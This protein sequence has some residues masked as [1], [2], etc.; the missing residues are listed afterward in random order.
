MADIAG[1]DADF[2][3]ISPREARLMDPQQRLAL[4]VAWEAL[5]HAGIPPRDLTGSDTGV[6]V[7]VG[8]DDYGRRLLEDLPR[9]EAWTGIGASPCGVANR[10]SHSLDLRGPS[11]AVDTACSS[12]LVAVHQAAQSLRLGEIPLALAGG[13]MLMAGPGLSVVLDA[14]GAIS[15]D[16]RSK[17][18]DAAADG[19]GRGEGG[20]FVVLKRL[21]D[22]Q[23]DGDRVL[24][25]IKGGAVHQDGRTEGIMAPSR[26]AQ[27]RLLRLAHQAAGVDPA[28]IDYVEAHGT[29]TR[30]GDPIEAGALAAVLGAGRSVDRPCLIGSLKPNIGHLEAGA[31]VAGLI[32]ASLAIDRG[33]I[34]ATL[35]TAGP[36]PA[37]AWERSG[38]ALVTRLTPWPAAV[39]PRRAGV[40]SYGYGGTIAYVVLE[41]TPPPVE[42]AAAASRPGVPHL[43]PLSGATPSGAR[44]NAARLADWLAAHSDTADRHA[45]LADVGRTLACH[46]SHLPARAVV[47][48]VNRGELIDGLRRVRV[49][50]AAEPCDPVWVFSGH[51]AQWV[52]MGRG[53]L[54][55][56][57]L[58]AEV[59]DELEP[60]YQEEVGFSPRQVLERGDLSRVDRIQAVTFAMQVGLAAVWRAYG[61]RAAAVI[62]HS[63]GEIAAAVAAGVL[64]QPDG[65]RLACRRSQLLRRV[66]GQGA[67]TM[68]ALPSDEVTARLAGEPEVSVAVV[69]SPGATV[70]AGT[71]A[72]VARVT[73]RFQAEGLAVRP[74]D[75][76]V[77]F[78]SAQMDRL[79]ADLADAARDLKTNP[80]EVPLYTTALADPRDRAE[81]DA[82][83]WAANLR[84]PVRF[85]AA[86]AAAAADGHRVFLEISAHP[87]VAHSIIQTV[88]DA[89]VAHTL[90]RGRPERRT[91]LENLGALHCHGVPVDWSVLHPGGDLVDMPTTAWRHERHWV[92]HPPAAAGGRGHDPAS[93]TLLGERTTV[94]G[95]TPVQLWRTRLDHAC[96]PYPGDHPV[97]GIEVVPAAVLLHTFL[98]AAGT[99]ALRDVSLQVPLA[100]APDRE[101]QV[102]CQD[103]ALRLSSRVDGDWLTHATA[104]VDSG[105][106]APVSAARL[107]GA[108]RD[109]GFVVER[110]A[111]LGVAAMGFPWRVEE[112]WRGEGTLSARVA[113]DPDTS[114]SSLTWAAVLDAALSA[115]S[116]VFPGPAVLRMPAHVAD[117]ALAGDPPA[118]ALIRVQVTGDECVDVDIAAADGAPAGRLG[119][120]S[121]GRPEAG[122]AGPGA[123]VYEIAWRPLAGQGEDAPLRSVAL[124]G[125]DPGLRAA[126]SREGILR[127]GP[128]ADAV[129]VAPRPRPGED[130]GEAALRL[131]LLL[132]E[133]VQSARGGRLWCVTR[134]A[135][136]PRAASGLAQTALWGLGRIAAGERPDRWGG[137]VDLPATPQ[138]RDIAALVRLLRGRW[139]EDLIG[140]DHGVATTARLAPTVTARPDAGPACR[141]DGTYLITGGTGALGLRVAQWLASRGAR[142]LVL[143]G[144]RPDASTASRPESPAP[145][146][147]PDATAPAGGP[148]PSRGARDLRR[149]LESVGVTVRVLSADVCDRDRMAQL[150]DPDTLGLPRIRGVVHAAGVIDNRFIHALDE[151][152]LRDVMRPKVTG[153]LV[154]HELFPPGS[155]DFFVLFSSAGQ[156]LR[157]PGQAAYAAGNA[158]LDGLARH[159]RATG[160]HETLSLAWTSWR[161]LGMSTSSAAVDAELAAHGTADITATEALRAWGHADS[162][163]AGNLAVLRVL[164]GSGGPPLLRDLTGPATAATVEWAHLT[165]P[166]RL[167]L[168]LTEARRAAAT[169]L[170]VD[171]DAL[172]THRPLADLGVDSLLSV[173]LRCILTER[174]GVPVPATLLW[175]HPTVAAVATY[176]ASLDTR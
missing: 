60:I 143:L 86:V 71:P 4:E 33:V 118:E 13:V 73:A 22:A 97:L 24:A 130:P 142:R 49:S 26:Q 37:I 106:A 91:L 167:E 93:H 168:L 95:T 81:R 131:A 153:A 1:F 158:F 121:F 117:T 56:E 122:P 55:D 82:A 17:A 40:A 61:V 70:M 173:E 29:G 100:T 65:A 31:G 138:A 59:V 90:R 94:H 89:F 44:A 169:V 23:R 150:V 149:A 102:V 66:A 9:I 111:S 54:A 72:G 87:V 108:P 14:A 105:G 104:Y 52:G 162:R 51:G 137:L 45:S 140:I 127:E 80:P 157:L 154:L 21:T 25:V 125:G 164:P 170:G 99:T 109:P 67:M 146:G 133:V 92:D 46:R 139:D 159:R 68:V 160:H 145:A 38:L 75:S 19:Y 132:A 135:R 113:A 11:V 144:R 120:L 83:Y 78:H 171:P 107:C 42:R 35:T 98:R 10:I 115:A 134:G 176:L 174:L 6:F 136:D 2:F 151:A 165:G 161:G 53:L 155:L 124:L 57:P 32:K 79:C 85:A 103:G 84:H 39:R 43:Y 63:V 166:G 8:A 175:N 76:D 5:E 27:E 30:V 28:T 128:E 126:L 112:L 62:G 119:A 34:P 3:G 148:E 64:D 15:P 152:S 50:S 69:A 96:R 147:G 20:G 16:G 74:V 36:S 18:F 88:P 47:V 116:V 77:A 12:S 129:V 101:V 48:A 163:A 123:L 41:Q 114:M 141:P 110:L 172:D 156:L 7:G 58:F